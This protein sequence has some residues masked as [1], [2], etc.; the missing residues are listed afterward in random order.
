MA[1]PAD[2]RTRLLTAALH[3]FE[4]E[5][6]RAT[7]LE[8]VARAAGMSRATV[9]RHFPGGREQLVADTITWEVGRFLARLGH[10][11]V[12]ERDLFGQLS[13]G[14]WWGHQAIGEHRLLQRILATEP[15]EFIVGFA[16]ADALLQG[17]VHGHLRALL[18]TTEL[19]SGVDRDEAADYLTRM[20]LSHLASHGRW[21]LS[22]R[23]EVERLVR[24]QFLAGVL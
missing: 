8:D 13:V 11:L 4:V 9:Y 2:T 22:D 23:A 7:S 10:A 17:E 20:F 21:D 18:E 14:L 12:G 15:E 24:T 16:D 6:L 19:R 3:C 1:D 5:G